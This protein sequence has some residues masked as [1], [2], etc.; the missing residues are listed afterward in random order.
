MQRDQCPLFMLLF[1]LY[2]VGL[3]FAFMTNEQLRIRTS[4]E[5]NQGVIPRLQGWLDSFTGY[6]DTIAKDI[7][8]VVY[9]DLDFKL[10]GVIDKVNGE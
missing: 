9:D 3:V 4:R 7:R 5:P 6:T 2:R 10:T 8:T 1:L